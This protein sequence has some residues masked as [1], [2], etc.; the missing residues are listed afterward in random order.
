MWL[1]ALLCIGCA[2]VAHTLS[3]LDAISV[4]P[5]L[6]NFTAF[7]QNNIEVANQLLTNSSTEPRTI[8]IPN[9]DAFANFEPQY[10]VS[11]WSLSAADL[12]ALLQY[13]I[14]VGKLT[15]ANFSQ[16][17]GLTVPSLLTGEQYNNRS[18]G[19]ELSSSFGNTEH[20]NGQVVYISSAG[21]SGSRKLAFRQS[22]TSDLQVRSGLGAEA[23]LTP[24]DGVW[25]GGMFQEVG[26]FLTLPASC[27]KTIRTS[28]LSSLDNAIN[29]T[30]LWDELNGS[31]NFTCLGPSNQAFLD[32]GNPETTL[33]E[34]ALAT[35]MRMH[36]IH[37]SVYTNFLVEGQEYPSDNN[38]IIRV[39][40]KGNDIY[41]NDAKVTN[42]NIITK[43]G[44]IHV[45]DRV[46]SPLQDLATSPSATQTAT[47][48]ST[49]T[50]GAATS[51]SAGQASTPLS[52]ILVALNL[53]GFAV[54]LFI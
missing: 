14:L 13:H 42:S 37:Q 43:N 16:P 45:L 19:P 48:T 17:S 51:K 30:H 3:L 11:I 10:G 21:Q 23:D 12:K 52:P 2:S 8:L 20:A 34:S 6:S 54:A 27:S 4:Y 29:R 22:G 47:S 5:K 40:I 38:L 44:V 46:M 18:A 50:A 28:G 32:A 53:F 15:A 1:V 36:T 31:S 49:G 7:Y 39:S 24:L 25:D 33:N 26:Q 9:N 35:A 41:F